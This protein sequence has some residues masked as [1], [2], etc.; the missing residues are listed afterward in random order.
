MTKKV[1]AIVLILGSLFSSLYSQAGQL[2]HLVPPPVLL[3]DKVRLE[4]RT[5]N[6]Q[7]P[8]DNVALFYRMEGEFNYHSAA[9]KKEGLIFL[10]EMP[11][12][13]LHPGN[14]EYYFAYQDARGDV[15]YLPHSNPEKQPFRL[16]ILPARPETSALGKEKIDIL[17][18][19]PQSEVLTS[20]D[21]LVLAFSIPLDIENPEKLRYKL[22]I[23][24]VDVTKLITRDGHLISFAPPTIRSGL[25]NAEL[26]IYNAVGKL[27][28]KK[29]FSFRV[30][31]K[32][33]GKKGFNSSANVF[34]DNRLQNINKQNDNFF[35]AGLRW[36]GSYKK[37]DFLANA[38]VS[39]EEA[40]SRQPVNRY[41]AQIRY[42][43][44]SRYNLYLKAGDI[45]ANYDPLSFWG[46]RV[47]GFG[48]GLNTKYFS[49]D[50]S[51]GQS[52]RAVEGKAIGDSITQ[53]GTYKQQFTAI[54]PQLSFGKYVS[55]SLNLVNS[56]E[57]PGSIKYGTNPKEALAMG[58]GIQLNLDNS[59]IVI[60][61][62]FQASIKNEDAQ[63]EIDFDTLAAHYDLSEADTRQAKKFIDIMESLG[64][65][66][67]SQGLAP[68]PSLAMQ[69]EAQLRYYQQ[70][71]RALYKK[72]DPE[73]TTPGNPYLLKDIQ[74]LFISDNIRL[75]DN[76]VFLNLYYN[77]YQNNL[78]D[79]DTRTDNAEMGGSI[80][81]YPL[82]RLPSLTLSYGNQ[83]RLNGLA[84]D[85]VDPDSTHFLLEDNRTQRIGLSSSYNFDLP[86]LRN[87]LTF[88]ASKYTRNDAVY[89]A[90]RSSFL[91]FNAGLRNRFS[92]PLT[93]RLNYANSNSGFGEADLENA[94]E[95]QKYYLSVD[96][97][98]RRVIGNSD[99]KPYLQLTFQKITNTLSGVKKKYNRN[100]Y[101]SGF[102]LT[103]AKFGNLSLRYDYIDYGTLYNIKDSV[104]SARYEVNF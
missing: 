87:T 93:T 8:L 39:S 88:S 16:Q 68:I 104:F 47:R 84:K 1:I 30:S 21:E 100:N 29:D 3:G 67:L 34:L 101:T 91:L 85:N 9:M 13:G 31:T 19:S 45:T 63:G 92:F 49:L 37:F 82:S 90:N 32:P 83:S 97:L 95:I 56:K 60:K 69:F 70:T 54:R 46:K 10:Y 20:P 27:L 81:Y 28:G 7:I 73:F 94:S 53:Y 44:S 14:M 33:S 86:G 42:N 50:Y 102:Y 80:S 25:H 103:N 5:L 41:T 4:A 18:L 38:L 96:Y 40:L 15:R 2:D 75:L 23:S 64:F 52:Y 12:T 79:K 11:T 6:N 58:S 35:R 66:T 55:W 78:S 51:A 17:V 77:A 65:L 72:I 26:S 71:L 61:G 62:N 74:G 89:P 36:K 99:L 48:A 76:Q 98:F 22:V 43:F 24:G 59:R 57:L